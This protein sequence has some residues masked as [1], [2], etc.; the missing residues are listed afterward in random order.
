MARIN[1]DISRTFSEFLL[2]PQLTSKKHQPANVSLCTP[3]ARYH[4]G[5]TSRRMLNV[6]FVAAS[7]Q[8]VS[9]PELAIALARCGGLAFIYCS[10]TIDNQAAMVNRVKNHK[11]GFVASDSNLRPDNTLA[12]AVALAR[13][14]GHSTMPVTEDGSARGVFV[15]ILTDNDYWEYEDELKAP[16]RDFM[17]PRKEVVF[18]TVGISLHE[19]NS[20]LRRNKLKCLPILDGDGRLHSLVFKKDYLDHRNNPDELLDDH[21]RLMVGA[22]VNTHDYQDRVPALVDAG[23]DVV[24]FDSSDGYSEFQRDA[25]LWT[26]ERYGDRLVIGGGNVV[27]AGAFRFLAQEAKLDFIKVGIEG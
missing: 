16:V 6:P 5:D 2:I 10:Q 26:R 27:D 4:T 9:G 19:A 3:L 8:A 23:V 15:G 24:C 21:K 22:G 14:T 20:L 13:R 7:M 25:A 18:G 1:D 17:T 11:A 12:E